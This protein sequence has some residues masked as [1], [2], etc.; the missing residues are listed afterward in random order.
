MRH[1]VKNNRLGRAH[2]HRKALMRNLITSI[3]MEKKIRTTKARAKELS[4]AIDKLFT[5]FRKK[6][7]ANG[8]RLLKTVFNNKQS[9]KEFVKINDQFADIKSGFTRITPIGFR[10]GDAAEMVQVEFCQK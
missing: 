6:D 8:I 5:S 4:R 7:L 9:S 3:F 1:R 10:S 2:D